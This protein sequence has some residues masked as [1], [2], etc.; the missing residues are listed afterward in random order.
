[1]WSLFV[2]CIITV[3]LPL[4]IV[5]RVYKIIYSQPTS[6]KIDFGTGMAISVV[7]KS[8]RPDW[9]HVAVTISAA[10]RSQQL[11]LEFRSTINIIIYLQLL[12]TRGLPP[13]SFLKISSC[14][15]IVIVLVN[16]SPF[17]Y[18]CVC[19][20][21]CNIFNFN[22]YYGNYDF[23]KPDW[24][25]K[26][27]IFPYS[28]SKSFIGVSNN[29][30]LLLDTCYRRIEQ[31]NHNR[32]SWFSDQS[33]TKYLQWIAAT[34]LWETVAKTKMEEYLIVTATVL[35]TRDNGFLYFFLIFGNYNF[36]NKFVTGLCF[37]HFCE[38]QSC[39]S[40]MIADRIGRYAVLVPSR[41]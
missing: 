16:K 7:P 4:S 24:L 37:V 35:Q 39:L 12:I 20:L 34:N 3:L 31:T 11:G 41:I 15:K 8:T 13:H 23:L 32:S 6:P 21:F 5:L 27:S 36:Y 33:A 18:I 29:K 26:H 2:A 17:V 19:L 25:I 14:E 28:G 10:A 30:K 40:P 9:P 1:M 38:N 22:L